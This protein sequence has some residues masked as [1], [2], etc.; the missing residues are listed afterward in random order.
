M[1]K[2]DLV[3]WEK[4]M[5]VAAA[6]AVEEEKSSGG[7]NYISTSNGILKVGGVPVP[8]NCM[9]VVILDHVHENSYYPGR[10]DPTNTKP[11]V[12]FALGRGNGEDLAPHENSSDPQ[13]D[14]CAECPMNEWGSSDYGKGKACKNSRRLALLDES[15]LEEGEGDVMYLKLPVTSVKN[16]SNYVKS[17]AGA[18]K[19]PPFGVI[20]EISVV[21][22]KKT[23]YQI[24]FKFVGLVEHDYMEL[25]MEK[26][27]E[28]SEIIMTPYSKYDDEEEEEEAP[29][30]LKTRRSEPEP[31]PRRRR[32]AEPEPAPRRRVP[33][34]NGQRRRVQ[35]DEA[36]VPRRRVAAETVEEPRRTA[37]RRSE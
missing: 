4:E 2:T 32:E 37:K 25:V 24:E 22:D 30:R 17:L 23:Q 1:A 7:M 13:S 29:R 8:D 3:A 12:C 14:I 20:T 27:G 28:A 9:Q 33:E 5:E 6:A 36:P 31:A 34:D 11:P 21:P 18:K 15:A 16:W 26:R 19:R 10:F 35:P